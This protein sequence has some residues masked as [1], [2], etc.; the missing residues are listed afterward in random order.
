MKAALFLLASVASA[1]SLSVLVPPAPHSVTL[2]V[3]P[4]V[5]GANVATAIKILRSTV[6]GAPLCSG[7]VAPTCYAAF[8]ATLPVDTV[9]PVTFKDLSV[10]PGQTYYYEAVATSPTGLS[11]P[12][13]EVKAVVP[14]DPLAPP[15]L[16]AVTQ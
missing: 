16:S 7:T 5:Q 1:Q 3:S 14:V 12:T 8:I 2:S 9:N 13:A 15:G 10:T 6:S 11:P 4:Y